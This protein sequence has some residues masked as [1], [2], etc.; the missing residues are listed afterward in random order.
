MKINIEITQ[1]YSDIAAIHDLLYNYNIH[2]SGNPRQANVCAKRVPG[3][4]ALLAVGEDGVRQGGLAYHWDRENA[5]LFIDYFFLEERYRGNGTGKLLFEY[6]LNW[7]A[8]NGVREIRLSTNTYQ[9]PGFYRKFGFEAV[10]EDHVPSP[11]YPDNIFY[12]FRKVIGC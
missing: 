3:Q 10:S 8:R 2:V 1:D 12:R 9:V 5:Q 6:I 7:A 4:A 11:N